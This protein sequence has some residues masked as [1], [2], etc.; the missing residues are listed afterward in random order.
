MI[1]NHADIVFSCMV[2]VLFGVLS[3]GLAIKVS[4]P[5]LIIKKR[6]LYIIGRDVENIYR[7]HEN[8]R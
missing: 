2:F 3:K 1:W 8:S 7:T 4:S 6:P 5:E